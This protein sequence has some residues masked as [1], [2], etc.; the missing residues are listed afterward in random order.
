[1]PGNHPGGGGGGA[2]AGAEEESLYHD[3]RLGMSQRE[4]ITAHGGQTWGWNSYVVH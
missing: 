3:H 1:M 2:G 4:T